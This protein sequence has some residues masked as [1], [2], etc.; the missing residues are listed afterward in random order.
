MAPP[1][2]ADIAHRI[3]RIVDKLRGQASF[4]RILLE[5]NRQGIIA[6]H[7]TLRRYLDLL[8]K[9][10]VLSVRERDVGS[11]QPQQLYTRHHSKPHL[12]AGPG[13]LNQHGL[14]WEMPDSDLYEVETDIEAMVRAKTS[15]ARGKDG[16][17][18]SLEDTLIQELRRDS[19]KE[20]GTTELVAAVL[21]TRTVD[22][23]YMLRRA[24]SQQTGQTVRQLF[25]K[26]TETFTSL[27]EN[28]EG[29]VF[30]EARGRFLKILRM[31]NSRGILKLVEAQ[32]RG[33]VGL[34]NVQGLSPDQIV[35]L[36][37]KQLGISG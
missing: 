37:G 26:I 12:W 6:W 19:A 3:L 11:V 31:Y 15:T 9:A 22:L 13:A 34:T 27:P 17:I 35:S 28:S 10:R 4:G 25:K 16:L 20:T 30:L 5:A 23:P 2:R 14:N 29:K 33:K 7:R 24:D 18:T 32:G 8:V 21:A 1:L 36:A